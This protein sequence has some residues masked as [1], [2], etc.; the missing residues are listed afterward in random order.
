MGGEE[1]KLFRG[2]L[3]VCKF[4]TGRRTAHEHYTSGFVVVLN[5]GHELWGWDS[6]YGGQF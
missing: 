5:L 6:G 2:D 1:V 4:Y 3:P